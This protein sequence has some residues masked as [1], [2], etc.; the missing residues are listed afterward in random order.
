M[1]VP[2]LPEGRRGT[3][4]VT[5]IGRT[6]RL[7]V[8]IVASWYPTADE[9]I[10]GIFVR[11]QAE[12]LAERHDVAVVAPRVSV[13]SRRPATW[14]AS[15]A[16]IRA[17]DTESSSGDMVPTLRPRALSVFRAPGLSERSYA[18]AVARA[19]RDRWGRR[20]P[21]LITAHVV[22]PAGLAAVRAGRSFGVPV[23]LTEHSG[24]FSVHLRTER[25]RRRVEE[26][27][28]G[29]DRVVAVGEGLRDEILHVAPVR[30]DVVGNVIA[31]DFFTAGS[32]PVRRAPTLRLLGV[33]F[34]K[35]Q[36]RFDLLLDAVAGAAVGGLPL[37]VVIVGD[38][39]DRDALAAQ[40]ARLGLADRVRIVPMGPRE[41]VLGW[42][43][44]CDALVS[45]SDHESFGLVVAEALATGRPVVATRSG[46]PQTFV[47]AETGILVPPGDADA[48]AHALLDLP[49]FLARFEP[50]VARTRMAARFGPDVFLDRMES[51]FEEVLA[52]RRGGAG[53]GPDG[54]RSP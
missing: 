4:L 6:K 50:D 52:G 36:K 21:D 34:L 33:G 3:T 49:A 45:P 54:T 29:V 8:A 30:V 16:R 39:P 15:L 18:H 26:T 12:V 5:T 2:D 48:L 42:L 13:V 40:V 20:G 9:P 22:L 31:R 46:G 43:A 38:G 32:H 11:D 35:S 41:D 10:G 44:W 53:P 28:R 1:V 23:V 51:I 25:G 14:R 27:L 24:P 7:R 17:T 37:Q 19:L 47:D